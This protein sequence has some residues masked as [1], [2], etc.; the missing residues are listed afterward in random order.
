MISWIVEF[1][2]ITNSPRR[3]GILTNCLTFI[4]GGVLSFI[5][6]Y[7]WYPAEAYLI[8]MLLVFCDFGTGIWYA[9]QQNKLETRKAKKVLA[10]LLAYT[11]IMFFAHQLAKYD[12]YLKWLPEA[13][14]F[15]IVI[16][17]LTSLTKNLSLLGF[18]PEKIST[19]F[20][21]KIDR[22]KNPEENS[23]NFHD[24]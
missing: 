23:I 19:I 12:L 4:L 6:H 8:V 22:Y 2:Q 7:I 11:I 3:F 10:S 21:E 5:N 17:N 9:Y 20:Y 13:V 1:F 16:I 14:F 24:H 18:I 15:P